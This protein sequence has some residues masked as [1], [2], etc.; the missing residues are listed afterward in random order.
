M[1]SRQQWTEGSIP[2]RGQEVPVR[3]GQMPQQEL[4]FYVDNPRIYTMV[5]RDAAV[6]SQEEIE[7]TLS[8][9]D[10]VKGL[11]HSIRTHGGLIDPVLVR[12][13]DYVVLEG[14]SRLAAY[15]LLAK[16]DPIRWGLIRVTLL[17]SD[18]SAEQVFALLGQYHLVGKKDWLPYEQAG[19][20][21]RRNVDHGVPITTIA[22][23][24]GYS[25][26]KIQH[27]V[28]VY[29]FMIRHNET[30]IDRW[31]YYDEYLKNAAIKR[32]R[33]ENPTMDDKVVEKIQN[34]EIRRAIDIRTNLSV[35]AKAGGKPLATFLREK[36]SFDAAFEMTADRSE[37]YSRFNRFRKAITSAEHDLS[38]LSDEQRKK[39][40]YEIRKIQ[41]I[42]KNLEKKI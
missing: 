31:S 24:M 3:H 6:P 14:N 5:G 13:T 9:M 36:D 21:Y 17:P 37:W 30:S 28:S 16:L 35:I 10:H 12:D 2:L 26:Q 7:S 4:L 29:A 41:Q 42:L 25:K 22:S 1:V 27:L 38:S 15:R 19:Y 8:G 11:V 20:F 34:N 18:I 33:Y 32:A 23:E 39:C 40:V